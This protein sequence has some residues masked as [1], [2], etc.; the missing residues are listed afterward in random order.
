[1]FEFVQ[2]VG[3]TEQRIALQTHLGRDIPNEI[4]AAITEQHRHRF[5]SLVNQ[6]APGWTVRK[7][8][9]GGYNCAGHV[10]ASRRTSI[11]ELRL[12]WPMIAADDGYRR[13]QHPQPDD[14]VFYVAAD[15]ELLHVGR[16]GELRQ[17]LSPESQ[18]LPWAVSKW[19]D[20]TG[21]VLHSVFDHPYSQPTY[22]NVTIEFW[23][24]RPT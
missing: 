12:A 4:G 15:G 16:I 21:E 19:S 3:S 8:P 23:T 6:H 18:R 9:T 24:D 2:L 14:L 17:G 1:M 20:W 11:Y 7:T 22:D 13:A 5:Q 10:W